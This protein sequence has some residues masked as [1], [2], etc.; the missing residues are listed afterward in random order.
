MRE[1]PDNGA[2]IERGAG[3][4]SRVAPD[5]HTTGHD[6]VVVGASAG[7][8]EALR[9]ICAEL[10]SDLPAAVFVVLHVPAIATSVLPAILHR[11]EE[12]RV[13]KGRRS[14]C[15]RVRV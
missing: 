10:P 6:I 14:E 13:G 5:E 8:V 4:R 2:I 15:R 12:R 9:A 3:Y 7:G 11:S 1:G